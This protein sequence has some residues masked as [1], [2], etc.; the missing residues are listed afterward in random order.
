MK[1][2][3]NR[4]VEDGIS[5]LAGAGIGM[6]LMYLLD[7]EE[8]PQRRQRLKRVAGDFMESA[9][10]NVSTALGA[11][12]GG[13][14]NFAS[15]MRDRAGNAFDN[16]S[17]YVSDTASGATGLFSKAADYGRDIYGRA[18]SA[19]SNAWHRSGDA[20]EDA[21]DYAGSFIPHI[22][23][24]AD[25][26]RHFWGQIICA[27]GSLGLGAGIVYYI[28]PDRGR[29]RRAKLRDK[30]VH[31]TN[32]TGDFFSRTGR[33]LRN[34]MYGYYAEGR[35]AASNMMGGS[36]SA[37]D[38]T[39]TN[40][41]RS[42]LGRSTRNISGL[43]IRCSNGRVSLSGTAPDA[44]ISSIV[45]IISG[46]RGVTGVDNQL[47]SGSTGNASNWSMAQGT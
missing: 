33:H 29:T 27:L 36:E 26:R 28:D 3:R 41:I 11:A 5:L 37:D 34:K 47:G 9:G 15:R 18:R 14:S 46:V 38:Q 17:D 32:E 45:T 43:N 35:S 7:P 6:A 19:V 24:E 42:E 30:F 1:R 20:A 21:V 12:S 8:G 40:R 10:T 39:L 13:A 4:A 16:T 22:E 44:E 23:T 25:R 2:S 31:F